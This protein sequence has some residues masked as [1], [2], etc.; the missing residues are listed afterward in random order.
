MADDVLLV[1][2]LDD[3]VTLLTLNRPQR[4]NALSIELMEAICEELNSLAADSRRRVVILRGAGPV[5]CS[6]MDLHEAA[7][8]Q[9]G[10]QTAEYVAR[11][12]ETV[13]QSPLVS[14]AAA[15]GAAL[16]GGAGLL[17][18]CDLA[19]ASEELK[20]G[21]P[22]VR[23]GLVPAL[24]AAHLQ[25]RLRDGELRE[26]MLLSE[27][28]N[29][30]R[31]R[32]LGLIQRIVAAEWLLDEA[33]SLAALITAGAPQAVRDTKRLLLDLRRTPATQAASLALEIHQRTR[34]GD[35][36]T[37][38]LAAFLQRREPRWPQ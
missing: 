1:E 15:H 35:D 25:G 12:L 18:C 6:G 21:F 37:E 16:A 3:A 23:R 20:I 31:A 26:L 33:K 34:E 14:I 17:A 24:V 8:P 9:S 4:R 2:H 11:L 30:Q 36:A 5:F 10:R 38:G 29:A 22:E 13:T 7:D 27:P 32:E 28:I 19:V